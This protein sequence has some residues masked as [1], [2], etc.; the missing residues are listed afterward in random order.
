MIEFKEFYVKPKLPE[1]LQKLNEL[2]Q[3]IWSTWDSDAYR[4][5]SRINPKLFR[6]YNHNPIK[7]LEKV[8]QSR[9]EELENDK[10]FIHEMES[11][12][13]MFISYLTFKSDESQKENR[14]TPQD[15]IA[16]FSMEYGLHESLPIYSG[17]LGILSGDHLKGSS[18][19]GIPLVGFGLLYRV[20]YFSQKIDMEG[21][22][23]ASYPEN[24]WISKPI[25]KVTDKDGKDLIVKIKIREDDVFIR[26]WEV[27][28]GNISLYLLDTNIEQNNPF[29]KTITDDLYVADQAKRILQEML[30]AF[31]SIEFMKKININPKLY[32][33]NEGHSA[34]LIIKRLND[35]IKEEKF[36]FEEAMELV[37]SSTVF[38]THTPVPA[39]NERFDIS[40]IEYFLKD[41]IEALGKSFDE[42]IAYGKLE[43]SN[44]FWMPVFA[45]KF[46]DYIN[47]VS[48]LHRKVSQKMWQQL[49]PD[50]YPDEIPIKAITNGVHIQTWLSRTNTRL[51]D[52]Y[53]GNDYKHMSG[54][55]KMWENVLEIP[56]IEIWEAHQRRKEQMIGFIRDRLIKSLIYTPYFSEKSGKANNI[57]NHN[58][59]IIGFARRF[60][61]YKRAA[62]ILQ[63][64]ERLKAILTN[65]SMP[66][67]FIFAGKA[68][69]ADN[70]GQELI[71]KLVEFAINNDLEDKFVFVEDYDMNIARH[72]VQGVDVWLNNPIKPNEAS[73]TSGM[74]AGLNGVLNFSVLDGWWP[75]C[76]NPKNGWAIDAGEGVQ[77][78]E[79]R[80]RLEANQIYDLIE[81]E[82]APLYYSR[83]K[84]GIPMQWVEMMKQSIYDVGKDFN[85]HRMLN[86]YCEKFY[87]PAVKKIK[88]ISDNNYKKLKE[89]TEFDKVI[90]ENWDKI[91]FIEANLGIS[92]NSILKS[93]ENIKIRA[94]IDTAGVDLK[95]LAVEIMYRY[96]ENNYKI[97]KMNAGNRKEN[98]VD[99][100]GELKI[101]ASGKQFINIRIRP[102]FEDLKT[103]PMIKWY[104][105]TEDK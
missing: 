100:N 37:K 77:D 60:A 87:I 16:Y 32:H 2:A 13:K 18:D 45:I 17:G 92:D 3:N 86:G 53:I 98:I 103:I 39:G 14:L 81:N 63:D 72:I 85:I 9:W 59:L 1:K 61:T 36:T 105:N 20:G 8:P 58:K 15:V 12:Y 7:L 74:K 93:G 51:F 80:D 97:I 46:S 10:G 91:K 25:K 41:K 29:Y 34:F 82:I 5:F 6:K 26:V 64:P 75:E 35:L 95:Y 27:K 73:G 62:L 49:F 52:R 31:G 79:I 28:V 67:Q 24:E 83:D 99:F 78:Q 11:V 40:L 38:T 56:N 4:L 84:N 71:K 23:I 33:L 22:Q 94:K 70:D 21:N 50:F 102:V 44:F 90:Y 57:L 47:G 42:F 66:V 76:Y 19:M 69:P 101:E 55:K 30:L 43:N 48:K 104:F 89:I 65:E 96:D 54:D 68:H 88:T